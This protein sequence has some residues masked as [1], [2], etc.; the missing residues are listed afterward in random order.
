MLR[1]LTRLFYYSTKHLSI[2]SGATFSTLLKIIGA[3]QG[4]GRRATV[5]YTAYFAHPPIY[6]TLVL[7]PPTYL[8]NP[9]IPI[10]RQPI[11]L[12]LGRYVV[13]STFGHAN[14]CS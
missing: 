1:C 2:V 5:R 6:A 12:R 9:A 3:A 14:C 4:T 7:R 8:R 11:Y 10:L 13:Y